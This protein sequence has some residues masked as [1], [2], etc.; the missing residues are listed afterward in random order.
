MFPPDIQAIHVIGDLFGASTDTTSITLQWII[1]YMLHY[2]E[3]QKRVQEEIDE[4]LG[5]E[6][7]P[8][9]R[10]RLK[11]P[12]TDATVAEVL[13]K[14]TTVPLG[15][16]HQT[17]EDVEFHGYF[18]P[19]NTWIMSNLYAVHH[20]PELWTE[21]DRF[22]PDRF[23]KENEHPTKNKRDFLIPFSVGKQYLSC[24]P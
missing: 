13:R 4:H 10:D 7:F 22:Q 9:M 16:P 14:V 1:I 15:V 20:D 21:P 17:L 24:N 11:L 6:R 2:P 5:Q 8:S 19:K 23:L 18:I 3:V 12:Y